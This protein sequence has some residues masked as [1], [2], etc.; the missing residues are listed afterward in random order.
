MPATHDSGASLVAHWLRLSAPSAEG[1]GLITGQ[2]TRSFM[3]LLRVHIATT[4][5]Q[6]R[7]INK[8]IKK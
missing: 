1:L 3:T 5:T 7:H 2:G 8:L 4:K 6:Q